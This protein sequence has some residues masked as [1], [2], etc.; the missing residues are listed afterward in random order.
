MRKPSG[1]ALLTFNPTFVPERILKNIGSGLLAQIWSGLL[2]LIVLPILVRGL[3]AERYGLLALSLALIGFAA[4]ADLGV[5]RAASKYLAE[6]YERN[7]LTRTQPHISSALTIAT[8]MGILGAALLALAAPVIVDRLLRVPPPLVKEAR[9]VLW[10]TA[11]GLLA[12]L[13]RLCFDGALAGHHRIVELSIGNAL[14]NTLKAGL[15]VAA[16]LAGKS[17]VG[18]VVANVCV[19][20]LHAGGLWLYLRHYFRG[21]VRIWFGWNRQVAHDLI[22]LGLF[23]ST[24]TLVTGILLL[25]F[26]RFVVAIFLPLAVLGYYSTAFDITSKQCYVSNPIGQAFFPVFSGKSGASRTEFERHYFHAVKMQAVGLTGLAAM[27]IVLGRPLLTYW[28]SPDIGVHTATIMAI[29]TVAML[30]SSYATLPYIAILVGSDRPQVCPKIFGAAFAVHVLLSLPLVKLMGVTGVALAVVVAFAVAF[31]VSSYWVSKHLLEH[32]SLFFHLTHGFAA[33]WAVAATV[34]ASWWFVVRPHV[35][36]LWTTLAAF[37][38][39]YLLCLLGCAVFAY[40]AK[41]RSHLRE[42]GR[43][44]MGLPINAQTAG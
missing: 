23:S 22:R 36:N 11:L 38:G 18:V 39:G 25:Y 40:S 35:H 31:I 12:V 7:E 4:I 28:I 44:A 29:L 33:A 13:L 27:L 10:I 34:G 9:S 1:K 24:A 15:S 26:D 30:L 2:G 3:G 21:R 8:I 16:V 17:I 5:G 43:K 20:Y 32:R 37:A 6:D 14:A 42:I 41:E 19:S